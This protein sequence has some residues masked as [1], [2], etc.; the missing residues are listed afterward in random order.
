MAMPVVF[1]RFE[2]VA[3]QL[4]DMLAEHCAYLLRRAPDLLLLPR[5]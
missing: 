3:D 4:P 5:H 2:G 1:R